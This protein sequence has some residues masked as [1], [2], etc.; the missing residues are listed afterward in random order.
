MKQIKDIDLKIGVSITLLG[1]LITFYLSTFENGGN[2]WDL[3]GTS[4]EKFLMKYGFW[5]VV[6]FSSSLIF[7]VFCVSLYLV[8]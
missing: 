8:F 3:F 7:M 2:H 4:T 6:F 5:L 1:L